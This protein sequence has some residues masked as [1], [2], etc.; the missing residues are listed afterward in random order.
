MNASAFL[1]LA[2]LPAGVIK[3]CDLFYGLSVKILWI[4]VKRTATPKKFANLLLRN[5]PKKLW[6][7]DFD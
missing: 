7:I 3:I 6:V 2:V 4:C 5:E 1:F